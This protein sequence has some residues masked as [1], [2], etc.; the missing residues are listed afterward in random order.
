LESD[1]RGEGA[2]KVIVEERIVMNPQNNFQTGFDKTLLNE[3]EFE[4]LLEG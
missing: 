2:D 1:T 3:D 4:A